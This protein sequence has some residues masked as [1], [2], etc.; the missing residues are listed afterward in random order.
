MMIYKEFDEAKESL[1]KAQPLSELPDVA[2][3]SVAV[4][5]SQT[6]DPLLIQLK[7]NQTNQIRNAAFSGDG[8]ETSNR[9]GSVFGGEEKAFWAEEQVVTAEIDYYD[10]MRIWFKNAF[11]YKI[12]P[13]RDIFDAMRDNAGIIRAIGLAVGLGIGAMFIAR[14]AITAGIVSIAAGIAILLAFPISKR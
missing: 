12:K 13:G 4:P 1:R 6:N 2:D 7:E 8:G 14:K 3:P 10:R 9:G 5:K 11:G